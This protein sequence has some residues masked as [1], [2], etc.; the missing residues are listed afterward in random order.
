MKSVSTQHDITSAVRRSIHLD[1]RAVDTEG[2]VY[3][4]E[5]QRSRDGAIPRRARF[6]SS[7]L[8]G[9]LLDKEENFRNLVDTYVIFITETDIW[10]YGLPIYKVERHFLNNQYIDFGDGTHIYYVNGAYRAD[11]PIGR[12]MHDFHC[13][14][15][16]HMYS[17]LLADRLSVVKGNEERS[18]HMGWNS[19]DIYEEGLQIGETRGE[20]RGKA[21]GASDKERQILFSMFRRNQFTNE[22]ISDMTSIPLETVNKFAQEYQNL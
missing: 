2:Q 5:I 3:D 13:N 6:Y 21:L 10:G 20:A 19:Q 4:I 12:L 14:K 1:I 7:K 22:L 17:S 15:A 9:D 18:I 16:E 8:D 11:D